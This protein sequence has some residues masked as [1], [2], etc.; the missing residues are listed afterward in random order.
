MQISEL[1][2]VLGVL[3]ASPRLFWWTM[4]L[5]ASSP[6]VIN[7]MFMSYST[8][9]LTIILLH[10]LIQACKFNIQSSRYLNP[11]DYLQAIHYQFY[12]RQCSLASNV[13]VQQMLQQGQYASYQCVWQPE[14]TR[15]HNQPNYADR[16]TLLESPPHILQLEDL[17]SI[18]RSVCT[19]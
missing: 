19:S 2:G 9:R 5:A 11:Q 18:A 6:G 3:A 16:W 4:N 13:P 17:I 14:W 15:Q 10:T 7:I 8:S 1:L 12:Q